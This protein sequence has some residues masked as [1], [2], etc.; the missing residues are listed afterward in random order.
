MR[1]KLLAYRVGLSSERIF[2]DFNDLVWRFRPTRGCP[3][4][5]FQSV[6]N[7]GIMKRDIGLAQR[8]ALASIE[9]RVPLLILV[10]KPDDG[11]IAF[12]N[13]GADAQ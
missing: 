3:V 1:A 6:N 5:F 7:V 9:G 11:D 2:Q 4:H 12:L 8:R 13:Q 10:A